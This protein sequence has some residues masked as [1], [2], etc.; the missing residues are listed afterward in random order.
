MKG[1][2]KM[3]SENCSWLASRGICYKTFYGR[4]LRMF[5]ISKSVR[6]YLAFKPNLMFADKTR[7]LPQWRVLERFSTEIGSGLTCKH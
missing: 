1:V 2:E 4:N 6:P 5:V 3:Y 7:S